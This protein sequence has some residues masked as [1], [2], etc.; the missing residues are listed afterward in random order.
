MGLSS[1]INT[2]LEDDFEIFDGVSSMLNKTEGS[3]DCVLQTR[4]TVGT[5]RARTGASQLKRRG[6]SPIHGLDDKSPVLCFVLIPKCL[7]LEFD[8]SWTLSMLEGL[9]LLEGKLI[10]VQ[11]SA[12]GEIE[13]RSSVS[14]SNATSDCDELYCGSSVCSGDNGVKFIRRFIF[15]KIPW[16]LDGFMKS[17]AKLT[18]GSLSSDESERLGFEAETGRKEQ[19]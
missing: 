17:A 18:I 13:P 5:V 4:L 15:S 12:L 3:S 8:F 6:A 9:D 16:S 10:A 2:S 11:R 1:G 7:G 14:T 19:D